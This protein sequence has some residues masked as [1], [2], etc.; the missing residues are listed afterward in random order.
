MDTTAPS[1]S[2]RL[3]LLLLHV[4]LL[5]VPHPLTLES[6]EEWEEDGEEEGE[7]DGG[8]VFEWVVGGGEESLILLCL[9]G[10][11]PRIV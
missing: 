3:L 10:R 9:L 5:L 8:V 11:G 1:A 7:E 4:F 2:T 6:Q